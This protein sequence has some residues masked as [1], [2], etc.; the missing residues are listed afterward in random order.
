MHKFMEWIFA[1]LINIEKFLRIVCVFFIMI[2]SLYWIM[3][4][5]GA[6]WWWMGFLTPMMEYILDLV[7]NIYSFSFDFWG[8]TI[9]LKYFNALL[10]MVVC[11]FGLKG[12]N[13][14]IEKLHEIYEDAHLLYKKTHENIFNNKLQS[15]VKNQEKQ[16]NDYQLFFQTKIAKRYLNRVKNID[17]SKEENKIKNILEKTT[18]TTSIKK[19]NGFLYCLNDFENIDNILEILFNVIESYE[20][21]DFIICIQIGNDFRKIKRLIDLQEWG[22][23]IISADTLCRYEYNNVKKYKTTNVGIFQRKENTLEVHEFVKN[24]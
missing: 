24:L 15:I 12:I 22:K 14:C 20:Y 9:E 7:N 16:I 4:L 1:S 18:E 13:I 8:K 2:M 21:V 10:L 6:S 17:F 3:N 23:I 5:I 19:L 11:I